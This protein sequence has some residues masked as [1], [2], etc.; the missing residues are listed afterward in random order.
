MRAAMARMGPVHGGGEFAG[1]LWDV[2]HI[3]MGAMGS[4]MGSRTLAAASGEEYAP[5]GQSPPTGH[6]Y[7]RA[8]SRSILEA[9]S[10][11]L[12]G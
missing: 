12:G 2:V 8:V 1:A 10:V 7:D 4:M 9:G 6:P 11:I 3:D 5:A